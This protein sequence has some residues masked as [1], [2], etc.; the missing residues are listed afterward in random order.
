MK[1]VR[2]SGTLPGMPLGKYALLNFRTEFAHKRFIVETV[3][4][5]LKKSGEWRS[6]GYRV[7]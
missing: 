5:V 4:L 7:N 3:T 1:N 6:A 2:E